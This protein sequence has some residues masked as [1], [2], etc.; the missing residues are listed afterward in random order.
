MQFSVETL[1]LL[2]RNVNGSFAPHPVFPQRLQVALA[3]VR[4]N[5]VELVRLP[6]F[7][8][9]HAED[10]RI[11]SE[12]VVALCRALALNTSVRSVV[13]FGNPLDTAAVRTLAD[14]LRGNERLE[15]LNISDCSLTTEHIGLL[16]AALVENSGLMILNLGQNAVDDA[17]A[18]ALVPALIA[19]NKLRTLELNLNDIGPIGCKAICRALRGTDSPSSL[20]YLGLWGNPILD[21]GAKRIAKMLRVNRSLTTLVLSGTGLTGEG[22]ALVCDV[23]AKHNTTVT[24]LQLQ[25]IDLS[26]DRGG[27]GLTAIISMLRKNMTLLELDLCEAGPL[28]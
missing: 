2:L 7:S 18:Q 14:L 4:A 21:V 20:E 1:L 23:L 27:R 22:V 16:A 28:A 26:T 8:D 15:W 5:A 13:L 24:S 3:E 17:G 9:E 12:G 6:W 11:P 10:V 19:K 25:R